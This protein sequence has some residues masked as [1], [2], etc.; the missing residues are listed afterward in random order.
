MECSS[1]LLK[2]TEQGIDVILESI[3]VVDFVKLKLLE[4]KFWVFN[5]IE[6]LEPKPPKIERDLSIEMLDDEI[7]GAL[8]IIEEIVEEI[9]ANCILGIWLSI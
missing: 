9:K 6:D 5:F 1:I 2:F 7:R 8:D 4:T 3:N